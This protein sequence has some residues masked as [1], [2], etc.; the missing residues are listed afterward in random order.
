MSKQ[1]NVM[2][3]DIS[4][5]FGFANAMAAGVFVKANCGYNTCKH[6]KSDCC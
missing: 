4:N 3:E 5:R 1:L 2:K 6:T